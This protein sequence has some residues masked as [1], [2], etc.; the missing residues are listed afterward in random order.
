M[1]MYLKNDTVNKEHSE[2]V[3][4]SIRSDVVYDVMFPTKQHWWL[5]KPQ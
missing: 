4:R 3:L 5:M 1:L 2:F